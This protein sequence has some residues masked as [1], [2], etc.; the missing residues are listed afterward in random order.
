MSPSEATPAEKRR[1]VGGA[2]RP[3]GGR[4]DR[5][6]GRRRPRARAFTSSQRMS[7]PSIR[8]ASSIARSARRRARIATSV[9]STVTRPSAD[10]PVTPAAT[11]ADFDHHVLASAHRLRRGRAASAGLSQD[12]RSALQV[13]RRVGRQRSDAGGVAGDRHRFQRC[14][15]PRQRPGRARSARAVRKPARALAHVPSATS[16]SPAARRTSSHPLQV[17]GARS[18]RIGLGPRQDLACAVLR[19][20]RSRADS[21]SGGLLQV[22]EQGVDAHAVNRR[23]AA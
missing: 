13:A 7:P 17:Q 8:G 12:R 23:P 14:R 21:P 2:Q 3:S 16:R 22:Q 6:G 4:P 11:A 18:R 10:R 15:V 1:P 9:L 20:G 5:A 19:V